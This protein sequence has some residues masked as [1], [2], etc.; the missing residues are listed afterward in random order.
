MELHK[1]LKLTRIKIDWYGVICSTGR[2]FEISIRN[3]KQQHFELL[4]NFNITLKIFDIKLFCY[5]GQ[6]F[7]ST[8]FANLS[9]YLKWGKQC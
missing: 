7:S 2:N 5:F 8:N 9:N 6:N 4:R 1:L 3:R